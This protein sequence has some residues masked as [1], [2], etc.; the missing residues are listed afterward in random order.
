MMGIGKYKLSSILDF[1][2]IVILDIIFS[3]RL[4]LKEMK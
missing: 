4:S 3:L 1:V 2:S